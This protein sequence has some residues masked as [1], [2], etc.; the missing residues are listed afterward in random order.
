[1]SYQIIAWLQSGTDFDLNSAATR[2]RKY[3]PE[4]QLFTDDQSLTLVL[5]GWKARLFLDDLPNVA[6]EAQEFP[7]LFPQCPRAAEIAQCLRRVEV[8]CPTDDPAMQHFDD[9]LLVCQALEQFRGII[10][11]DPLSGQLI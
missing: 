10:L 3:F 1:M 2:V 9:F 11:F 8:L 4:A 7:S 5:Q 6:L